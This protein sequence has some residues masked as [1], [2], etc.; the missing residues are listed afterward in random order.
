MLRGNFSLVGLGK[1]ASDMVEIRGRECLGRIRRVKIPLA[2]PGCGVPRCNN[3][4]I[5]LV[6]N[7]IEVVSG[8]GKMMWGSNVTCFHLKFGGTHA[9][10]T[11]GINWK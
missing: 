1:S 5:F 4:L 6:W 9:K 10:C 7:E 8:V 2:P 3:F 11:G